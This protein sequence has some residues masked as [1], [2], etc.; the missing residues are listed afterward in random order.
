MEVIEGSGNFS[1]P[2]ETSLTIGNFDGVHLG[3][4]ELL[5]RTVAH[6]RDLH[7][8]AVAL[9]FTPHPVR[10]FTPRARFYEITSLGEKASRME[11]LGIDLLVVESFTGAI[12]GMGPEEFARTVVHERMR[13]RFVTV[14]YDF[15]FGRNRTGS[16]GMLRRIGRELGFEVDIVPPLM[17]GGAI[18]SSSRI[19][20]L[21]LSGR[22][23]EAEELLCRPYVVSGRVI[24]GAARG[25]KLGF[26][27]AN[28]EFVQELLP[29]PGVY[30]IDAAVGGVVRRG[31]ANV[32]FNPTFGENSLGVEVHLLDFAGDL[33]GQDMSVRFRDRIRDERKFKSVEELVRQ[34]EKDVGYARSAQ[35]T[36]HPETEGAVSGRQREG[37]GQ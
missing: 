16:P 26:P 25:R 15:T 2:G 30:V 35:L 10:F 17:R 19:R 33:Y 6:A 8:R 34:I 32:G 24:P 27:T 1:P 4:R 20:E 12:G 36:T 22:V 9:T 28:V 21:L 13:A 3:H 5:R 18:V 14:G 23:R 29:L 11:K 37:G 7:I 31:V